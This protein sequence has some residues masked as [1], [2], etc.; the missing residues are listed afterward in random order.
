VLAAAVG[1]CETAAAWTDSLGNTAGP[2]EG[3][4]VWM[5][6]FSL[7]ARAMRED[8]RGV[9]LSSRPSLENHS[10]TDPEDGYYRQVLTTSVTAR[11]LR[12]MHTP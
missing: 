9:F 11:N 5:V 6:R 2:Y 1:G 10:P 3:T 4:E 8:E 12:M 7:V